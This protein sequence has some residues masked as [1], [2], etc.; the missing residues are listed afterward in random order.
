MDLLNT[1]ETLRFERNGEKATLSAISDLSSDPMD[2]A[3]PLDRSDSLGSDLVCT[4]VGVNREEVGVVRVEDLADQEEVEVLQKYDIDVS[5]KDGKHTVEVPDEVI[6]DSTSLWED[7]IVEKFLDLVPHVAKVHMVL[8][9]IWSYSELDSKVEVYEVNATTMRFRV[10]NPKARAKVLR[11]GMWNIAGVPMVVAKWTPKTEE[12]K[13]E[14]EAI[15]MWVHLRK[16]PLHMYSWKG[17]SF[18]TTAV[19]FPARLH[20]ETVVCS[21]FEVAK[22][23]VNVDVSKVLPKEINFTKNGKE[24]TVQFHYPWLPSRCNLCEKW[25]HVDKVCVMKSKGM[26]LNERSNTRIDAPVDDAEVVETVNEKEMEKEGSNNSIAEKAVSDIGT[27]Q[28]ASVKA[29]SLVSPSKVGRAQVQSPSKPADE[30]MISASKFS[31]LSDEVEEGEILVDEQQGNQIKEVEVSE[32]E[33]DS[34]ADLL[35]DHI[36]DLQ[37][38]EK[39]KSVQNKGKKRGRKAKAQDANLMSTS[40][41]IQQ[42]FEHSVVRDWVNGNDL[43]FGCI[44]ETKV[45]ERKVEGILKKV[46]RDWSSMTNYEHSQGGRIWLVWRDTIRVTPVYKSDQMITCSVG[47]QGEEEFFCTFIYASNLVEGRKELWEDICHHKNS[48]LFQIKAWVLMGDFN[49]ILEGE[50]NSG[51]SDLG[52]L[53]CGMRD[54]QRMVLHC[55]LS[56]MGYQGPLFTWCNKREEGVICKKLDRVLINDVGQQRFSSAFSVFESGGCSD[57]M[58]CKIQL[59]ASGEKIRRPFKYVNAIGS[60]PQF[61]PMVKEQ[62]QN[63]IRELRCSDGTT[64]SNHSDIKK[65]AERFFSEFLNQIPGSYQGASVE[66]LQSLFGF[67]CTAEDCRLLESEVTE[68]EVHKV[69]FSMPSYKSPGPDGY[70]CEFFKATWSVLGKEFTIAVQSVFRFCF[71]HK[72]INSTILALVPKKTDSMEMKDYRPIACCNVLY[73][74]VSKILA[75]RLKGASS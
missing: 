75:N 66:E 46:F 48:P 34:D 22:V 55:N 31:I 70:P 5:M 38:K 40:V 62:A 42:T 2:S 4:E 7:F 6:S 69:L 71:L 50:K 63:A 19:G 57:L 32:T 24:F 51:F 44:L 67:R 52:R 25:G 26:K 27:S 18:I 14:E 74:V 60:L 56:D 8:N 59:L 43:K 68:E 41:Q 16:V 28:E 11:R 17:L 30:V 20:P 23:F 36:L 33:G 37:S 1:E 53:P 72:G 64:V 21:N 15:P 10:S 45:K 49:E 3:I 47:M 35:K 54:F 13:Q 39:D 12:E 58:R 9:K 61:L 29:W 65:E 73:K